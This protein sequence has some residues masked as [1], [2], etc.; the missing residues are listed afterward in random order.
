M[1]D[2]VCIQDH[3]PDAPEEKKRIEDNGGLVLAKSG[4]HRVVWQRPR[5]IKGPLRRCTVVDNVPFLAVARALGSYI[6]S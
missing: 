6:V 1:L 3:K 5:V 4:V 2:V